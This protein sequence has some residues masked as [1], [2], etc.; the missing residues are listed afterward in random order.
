M[1]ERSVSLGRRASE[2][3]VGEKW[4]SSLRVYIILKILLN[5]F[6][7][8]SLTERVKLPSLSLISP[9]YHGS[10]EVPLPVKR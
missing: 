5:A 7:L 10:H 3:V 8:D 4:S 1:N 9:F 6:V 2:L